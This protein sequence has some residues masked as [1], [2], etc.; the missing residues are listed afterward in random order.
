MLKERRSLGG[1]GL[2]NSEQRNKKGS[3]GENALT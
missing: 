3:L 1:S 2:L